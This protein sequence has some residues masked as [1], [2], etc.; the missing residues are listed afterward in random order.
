MINNYLKQQVLSATHDEIFSMLLEKCVILSSTV[1]V[2]ISRLLDIITALT[3]YL[4]RDIEN[5]FIDEID[6]LLG[7]LTLEVTK[8]NLTKDAEVLAGITTVFRNLSDAWK[9]RIKNTN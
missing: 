8:Y 5:E 2:D 4:N 1:P 7:F 9:I 6:A 3:L